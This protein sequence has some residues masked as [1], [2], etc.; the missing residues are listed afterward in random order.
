[1]LAAP[2]H[3]VFHAIGDSTRRRLLRVLADEEMSVTKISEHFPMSRVAVSKHLQVLLNAGL[4]GER[5]QGR[6]RR[7][8]LQ[9]AP[10]LEVR[11]WLS[12]YERFWDN[13][14]VALKGFVETEEANN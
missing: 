8:R 6:E 2:K 11:Q 14:M 9:P 4:V 12:F 10:L 1:M 13:K 7:Y 3:D 5:K